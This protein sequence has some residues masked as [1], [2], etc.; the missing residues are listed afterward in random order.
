MFTPTCLIYVHIF[1]LIYRPIKTLISHIH[2]SIHLTSPSI[3][4]VFLASKIK[5]RMY[6]V[7]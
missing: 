1:Y 6:Y 4:L 2:Q 7:D 5:E 3:N